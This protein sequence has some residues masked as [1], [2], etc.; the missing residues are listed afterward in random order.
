[1]ST[2]VI[3]GGSGLVGTALS[4]L[5]SAKGYDVIIIGRN[6]K[7]SGTAN[8]KIRYASWDID[9]QTI[10]PGTIEK[11]DY[12]I[13]LAG[14]GVAE[15]RWT[16]KRKK[17]IL[18]SRVK[19]SALLVKVLKETPNSVKA[20]I[21]ASAIGWYGADPLVPNPNPFVETDPASADFL[22][23]TCLQWENSIAPV[24][25]LGKR[26]VILRTGI[27]LSTEGGALKEFMQPLRFGVAAI[28]GNGKQVIS[29]IHMD[30][31]CR[32]YLQAIEN[33]SLQ[34]VYNAV[35]PKPVS[36]KELTFCLAKYKRKQFYLPIHVPGLVLKIALGQMSIEVLKSTTV[37]AAKIR[38][39]AFNFVYPTVE[40]A[41]NQLLIK[42]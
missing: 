22:G 14:A 15:K 40:A 4:G 39:A 25:L 28:L 42:K 27:V 31:L 10:A 23:D 20:V 18:E 16:A 1:M 5:L 6:A 17:Q 12:I 30:D 38:N 3:T 13:H 41:V 36:N 11:A 24:T 21:S 29:W 19:S 2:V 35:A 9:A 26:L 37:S 8:P 32:M 34:G 33:E 7:G